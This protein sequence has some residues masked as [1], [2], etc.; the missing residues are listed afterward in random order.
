MRARGIVVP[1]AVRAQILWAIFSH[2]GGEG[3]GRPASGERAE[4]LRSFRRVH[5][6]A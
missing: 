6:C 2:D 4:L 3:E 1:A 5:N